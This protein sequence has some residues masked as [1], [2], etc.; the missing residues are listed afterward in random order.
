MERHLAS[1]L[2]AVIVA[3]G[4]G[5]VSTGTCFSALG[6]KGLTFDRLFSTWGF[7]S[8]LDDQ[9]K[10]LLRCLRGSRPWA[11]SANQSVSVRSMGAL[12]FL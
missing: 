1:W 4:A 2:S 6:T 8:S 7:S 3:G 5:G 11:R 12:L 9:E 10:L